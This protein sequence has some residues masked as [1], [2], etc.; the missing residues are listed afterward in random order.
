M[1]LDQ[2]GLRGLILVVVLALVGGC[3]VSLQEEAESLPAGAIPSLSPSTPGTHVTPA[4][5]ESTVYFVS[6][7]E[8]EGVRQPVADLTAAAVM[9]ALTVG[10]PADR[11]AE[12]RTLLNDRLSGPM[13]EVVSVS[14]SNQVNLQTT[15][16]FF[17]LPLLDQTLL[18]GQ[19]VLSMD[20][21]GLNR[22][23]IQ[24]PTGNPMALSL[25]DGRVVV[26]PVTAV[27]FAGLVKT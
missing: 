2:C 16:A 21:I 3:G 8:L 6:G 7:R 27:D 22:T 11:S 10:P 25:P 12:L 13:I 15:N 19:V 9:T 17:A 23:T 5:S 20:R 18:V 1:R 14:P 4:A 26:G 24:D